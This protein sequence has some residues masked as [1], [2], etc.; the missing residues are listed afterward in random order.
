[1]GVVVEG[2]DK[3]SPHLFVEEMQGTIDIELGESGVGEGGR[4]KN[5][6]H[7]KKEVLPGAGEYNAMHP[8]KASVETSEASASTNPAADDQEQRLRPWNQR[9]VDDQEQRLR[10]WNQGRAAA[11]AEPPQATIEELVDKLA[12]GHL[13][14]QA[15]LNRLE[16]EPDDLPVEPVGASAPPSSMPGAAAADKTACLKEK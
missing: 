10:P 7:E 14:T 15:E 5:P 3:L 12:H 13:L 4:S 1:M 9:P 6:M 2:A 11:A 8:S 16:Q